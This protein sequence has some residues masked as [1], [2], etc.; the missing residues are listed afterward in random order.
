MSSFSDDT[1][2]TGG[3][4]SALPREGT[5]L[6]FLGGLPGSGKTHYANQL[7]QQGWV[8]YDD[9]QRC[10][11]GN[12]PRFR[13]SRHYAELVSHLQGGQRC[14]VSDIRVIH[15]EYRRDAEAT[16]RQD[17]GNVPTELRLFKNDPK[18]CAENVRN[19][20]DGRRVKPRLEAIEFWSKHYS[21][22]RDAI[23]HS[24]W[25]PPIGP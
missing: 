13:D 22:P 5:Q 4:S 1:M 23:L 2:T 20:G 11:D 17:V 15:D 9:F 8:F 14:I 6:V 21:A 19:A 3:F 10:A 16:L 7:E 12:S 24:V 25:R 18:Q